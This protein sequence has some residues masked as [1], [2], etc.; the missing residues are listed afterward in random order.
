MHRFG[1][2]PR[3]CRSASFVVLCLCIVAFAPQAGMVSSCPCSF[4]LPFSFDTFLPSS[5][6]EVPV[7]TVFC[8]TWGDSPR[9]SQARVYTSRVDGIIAS[10]CRIVRQTTESLPHIQTT[11]TRTCDAIALAAPFDSLDRPH[12]KWVG[13]PLRLF[14][15]PPRRASCTSCTANNAPISVTPGAVCTRQVLVMFV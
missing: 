2:L 15:A 1:C 4:G 14:L 11:N 8:G 10:L 6:E 3:I 9:A 12:R 13:S 7:Y 5:V